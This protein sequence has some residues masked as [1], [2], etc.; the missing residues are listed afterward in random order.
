VGLAGSQTQPRFEVFWVWLNMALGCR[1]YGAQP[2][3]DVAL[4]LLLL[5]RNPS[6]RWSFGVGTAR[7]DPRL[8]LGLAVQDP[9]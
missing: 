9:K 8:A 6:A 1:P 2:K 4:G 5:C 3:R 7:D